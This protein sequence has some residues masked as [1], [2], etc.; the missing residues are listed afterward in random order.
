[1]ARPK[2]YIETPEERKERLKAYHAN[3]RKANPDKVRRYSRSNGKRHREKKREWIYGLK[4]KPC[5]D[6]GGSFPPCVMDFHHRPGEEKV[7]ELN[8]VCWSRKEEVI[9]TEIAKCDLICSN[10][11]RI[12]HHG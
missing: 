6:C 2:T 9:L 7:L 10:C 3:W 1:M 11:H 12:R 4:D 5:M 8:S